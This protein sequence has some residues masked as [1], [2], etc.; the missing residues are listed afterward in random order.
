[1][2]ALQS[3]YALDLFQFLL[4]LFDDLK[5]NACESTLWVCDSG[6]SQPFSLDLQ[7]TGSLLIL[8]IQFHHS[9]DGLNLQI[10]PETVLI[11]GERLNGLDRQNYS[12]P[13]FPISR[14]QS[15]IPLPSSIQPQTAI[16]ELT[17]TTL[18][19]TMMKTH[20]SQRTAKITVGARGQLLPYAMATSAESELN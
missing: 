20:E 11:K 1:M 12:E 8:K 14:F 7:E 16:A 19:L 6:I 17:G 5:Q 15:L 18:T 4:R 13:G 10:T 2:T 3:R 9:R